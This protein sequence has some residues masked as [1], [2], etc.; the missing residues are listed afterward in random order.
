MRAA[1]HVLAFTLLLAL[2]GCTTIQPVPVADLSPTPIFGHDDFDRVLQRFVNDA[3]RVDYAGLQRDPADLDRYYARVATYSP[4]SHPDLFPTAASRLAY[5]INAYNAVAIK[6][7]LAAYPING[8]GDVR[9][10]FPFNL[11]MKRGGFF[12]FRR[13]AYGGKTTSLYY[14]EH[15]VIRKRFREPRVH[16]ALNCASRGC[17]RLPTMA[18][19]GE[20]LDEQLE[21]E[22][23][24]FFSEQRNLR[25][26]H[27]ARTVYLSSILKWYK[28][29]FLGWYAKRF[30]DAAATL[31]NYVAHYAPERQADLERAA[32]YAIEFVP[33]DWRLNDRDA[34]A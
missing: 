23:R 20:R 31:L 17:P 16:F 2:A 24:R 1:L 18:F 29:E 15:Y 8:V 22:A 14:L 25:I 28:A 33:Y 21:R 30:P 34:P 12:F 4:D 27:A 9:A 19:T 11:F 13:A 7:V 32:A 10:P 3:G 6:T 26:D 5:W